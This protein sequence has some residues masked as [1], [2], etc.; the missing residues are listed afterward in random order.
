M[1]IVEAHRSLCSTVASSPIL[2]VQLA[3]RALTACNYS[4]NHLL[5]L[6]VDVMGSASTGAA[7]HGT[8]AS[9]FLQIPTGFLNVPERLRANFLPALRHWCNSPLSGALIALAAT[10][11]C[12]QLQSLRL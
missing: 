1:R 3:R 8:C 11:V 2:A 9:H 6:L 4:Q 7:Q 5:A 10:Y 12:K